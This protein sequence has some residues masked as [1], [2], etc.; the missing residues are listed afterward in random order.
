MSVRIDTLTAPPE[1]G[2]MYLVPT[3]RGRWNGYLLA[4]PV[5]GPRHNDATCLNFPKFHYHVDW[6][7]VRAPSEPSLR[8][9][10][11]L[12]T[13]SAPLMMDGNGYQPNLPEP[14]WRLRRCRRIK[15]PAS[16]DALRRTQTHQGFLCH[17]DEYAGRQAKHDGRGWVCPHRMVS[18]ADRPVVKGVVTCPLHFLRI[19]HATG[20][21]MDP[22]QTEKQGRLVLHGGNR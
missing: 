8:Q 6:R 21:V 12:Y 22:P 9:Q 7:F 3:V 1:V 15:N 18:L 16:F 19:D 17:F 2:K 5:C 20:V 4:W 14:V 13:L 11:F 10:F